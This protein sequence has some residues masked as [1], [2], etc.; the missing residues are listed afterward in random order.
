M[1][2]ALSKSVLAALSRERA[3]RDAPL[4]GPGRSLPRRIAERRDFLRDEIPAR[5]DANGAKAL[6]VGLR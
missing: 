5:R 2:I 6:A 1:K 4:L 3:A